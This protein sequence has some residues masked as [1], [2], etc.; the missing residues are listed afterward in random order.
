MGD[1]G[2]FTTLQLQ[3]LYQKAFDRV[4]LAF[5]FLSSEPLLG[6]QHAHKRK[7]NPQKEAIVPQGFFGH[8]AAPCLLL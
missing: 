2:E 7:R 6:E 3:V 8:L 4:E 5:D 1:I